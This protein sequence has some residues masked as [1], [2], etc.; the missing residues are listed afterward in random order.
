MS[1]LNFDLKQVVKAAV[2]C[3][4]NTPFVSFKLGTSNKCAFNFVLCQ[5]EGN[6]MQ[7]GIKMLLL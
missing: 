6:F 4:D 3:T 1:N 5:K 2:I 7:S